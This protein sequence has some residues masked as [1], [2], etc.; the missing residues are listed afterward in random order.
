MSRRPEPVRGA[1]RAAR[2]RKVAAPPRRRSS[3]GAAAAAVERSEAASGL[4]SGH[5]TVTPEWSDAFSE[6]WD[7][8]ASGLVSHYTR[9]ASVAQ[10]ETQHA[11][12]HARAESAKRGPARRA[13]DCTPDGRWVHCG[14]AAF[15]VGGC[16]QPLCKSCQGRKFGATR[17]RILRSLEAAPL[18]RGRAWRL[19]TLSPPQRATPRETL[20]DLQLA[21]KRMRAWLHKRFGSF[22]YVA[23]VE[24]GGR[25]GIHLHIVAA[26]PYVDFRELGAEWERAFP[27]AVSGTCDVRGR[28]TSGKKLARY[29]A[30]YATK[31]AEL[32]TLPPE[33]AAE[34][35]VAM[36]ARRRVM[37]SQGFWQPPAPRCDTC[38]CSYALAEGRGLALAAAGRTSELPRVADP[39]QTGLW[40]GPPTRNPDVIETQWSAWYRAATANGKVV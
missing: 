26:W 24:V 29:A 31:G 38:G 27:G 13:A 30:K 16:K 3:G 34:L 7:R 10:R 39:S 36:H 35:L 11:W 4:D 1:G 19:V 17:R 40:T 21:W 2:R 8:A 5:T 32:H 6:A 37:A 14:C 12:A 18:A 28:S 20:D 23:I 22:H 25:G 15:S 9:K 33:Y